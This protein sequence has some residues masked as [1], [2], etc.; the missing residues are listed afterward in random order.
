MARYFT[1]FIIISCIL[2]NACSRLD[3]MKIPKG[4]SKLIVVLDSNSNFFVDKVVAESDLVQYKL[5]KNYDTKKNDIVYVNDSLQ[6]NTYQ[7]TL[8]SLL[9]RSLCLPLTLTK[10]TVIVIKRSQ[11]QNYETVDDAR[12]LLTDL[13]NTDTVCIAYSSIGCFHQY[14][15]RTLI[16]GN[17]DGF[18]AEFVTD[19]SRDDRYQKIVSIKRQLPFSF[20]DTLKRL[21]HSC[22]DGFYRQ[23]KIR[24]QCERDLAKAKTATDSMRANF[25]FY[26]STTSSS[27]YLNRGNKVFELTNNGINEIPYYYEFLKA[28]KLE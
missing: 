4:Y 3:K 14:S 20:I 24:I 1:M 16:Y 12:H 26:T 28:L 11:L 10:D 15:N 27:I 8:I 5:F 18:L 7:I 19:T 21:E 23:Q 6:N 25:G 13:Q 17:R 22:V 2:A 9:N